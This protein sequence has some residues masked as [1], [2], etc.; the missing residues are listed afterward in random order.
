MEPQPVTIADIGELLQIVNSPGVRRTGSSHDTEG[1]EP[2]CDV[3]LNC[4]LELGGVEL[5]SFIDGNPTQRLSPEAK[6]P[7]GLVQRMVA[8]C[9]RV[10]DR[11]RTD[12]GDAVLNRIRKMCGQ[13]QREGSEVRFVS[14]AR[15][16]AVKRLNPSNPLTNPAYR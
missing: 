4:A 3:R 2:C 9:G 15:E 14:A 6:Q 1:T 10:E 5:R 8:F 12:G 7:G 13:G 11:L 16:R